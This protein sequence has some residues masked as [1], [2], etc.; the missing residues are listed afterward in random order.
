MSVTEARPEVEVVT[1]PRGRRP[2]AVLLLGVV[3]GLVAIAVLGVVLLPDPLAPVVADRYLPPSWPHVFGTDHLGR[4]VASRVVHGGLRT[5][6]LAA[7]AGALTVAVGGAMGLVAGFE[8]GRPAA[9]IAE[10][11]VQALLAFPSIW[12]PLVIVAIMG[13][14]DV[15]FIGTLA[16]VGLPQV[17]WVIRG[18]VAQLREQPFVEAA[19]ALGFGRGRVLAFE[20]TPHVLP[21]LRVLALLQL[22]RAVLTVSALA[23]LGLGPGVRRPTWGLMIAEGRTGFPDQWWPVTFPSL[24]L[25]VLVVAAGATSRRFDRSDQHRSD[26]SREERST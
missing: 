5:V 19:A 14:S 23:F 20:L 3:V 10:L 24:A 18:D 25:I 17:Y 21:T 1:P 8:P 16:L 4:D 15:T 13:T 9:H 2:R 26:Q 22:R 11:G 7:A 6:G 12:L